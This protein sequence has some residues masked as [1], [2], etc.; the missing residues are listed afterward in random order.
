MNI[1]IIA[2]IKVKAVGCY[3]AE[4]KIHDEDGNVLEEFFDYFPK[5]PIKSVASQMGQQ[6]WKTVHRNESW[7]PVFLNADFPINIPNWIRRKVHA[8]IEADQISAAADLGRLETEEVDGGI[9][10]KS[11]DE[12][13]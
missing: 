11:A 10:F 1:V 5:Q 7:L 12:T 3:S 9:H 13:E 8:A 6:L 4:Y 2:S